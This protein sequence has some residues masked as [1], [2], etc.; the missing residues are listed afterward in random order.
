MDSEIWT[1][2]AEDGVQPENVDIVVEPVTADI[3]VVEQKE[4][5]IDIVTSTMDSS[6]AKLAKGTF[7]RHKHQ[8][9]HKP[10]HKTNA[11]TFYLCLKR[12]AHGSK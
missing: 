5:I 1:Q 7:V 10:C 4:S 3:P 12:L 11:D 8:T 6:S 2:P 9:Q